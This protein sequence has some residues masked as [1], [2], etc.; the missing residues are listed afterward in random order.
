MAIDTR[1][2]KFTFNGKPIKLAGDHTWNTVQRIGG[3]RVSIDR[4]TGNFTR[5][6]TI[7]TKRANF[8]ETQWGSN[9]PGPLKIQ[10]VPW[11]KDG[12]LNSSYYK[13]LRRTLRQAEERDLITGVVLFE[14]SITGNIDG[15]WD[16][17][18]FN[19]LG[20]KSASEVHTEGRWNKWQREH[21]RR[22]ANIVNDFPGAMA[23]VGNELHRSSTKWFQGAVVR[24]WRKFSKKPIGVSYAT[25]MKPSRGRSQNWL[26][27]QG[28]DWI[29]PAGAEPIKGF[30][31]P[32]VF[33]TDHTSPL[34]SNVGALR[35]AWEDG[36]PLWLMNGFEGNVLRNTNSLRPDLDFIRSIL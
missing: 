26:T 27:K 11:R 9:S 23:E 19:G 12:S 2:D 36:R 29:A 22:V 32:Q 25:G 13:S 21:V 30:K 1:G 10:D 5:L 18:P 6:W 20:P 8:S 4:I 3:R 16:H 33:D 35:S 24:W 7:E 15:A 31:G 14:G 34:R 17:H 28:A